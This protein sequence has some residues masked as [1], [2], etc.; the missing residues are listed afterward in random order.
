LKIGYFGSPSL[1]ARLLSE[2]LD[3][4]IQIEFVVTNEDK[5]RGRSKTP[6]PTEVA[7]LAQKKGIPLFRFP[8]L[9][10]EEV[11]RELKKYPCELYF[12]FAYGKLLPKNIFTIPP[13]GTVNLHASLLPKL[14]GASPFQSA[15]LGGFKT[16][17]WTLQLITEELDAGD[18]LHSKEIPIDPD[19]S[20]GEL[21][22]SMLPSAVEICR[23]VLND[24]NCYYQ[25]RK[26]Q[27]HEEA[28]Y[29]KKIKTEMTIINWNQPAVEIHNQ[30]RA[31]NPSPVARSIFRNKVILIYKSRPVIHDR[32]SAIEKQLI[33]APP[34]ST[35]VFSEGKQ[36]RL[37]VNTSK[38][39]LELLQLQPENK[40]IMDSLSFINGYRLEEGEY[41]G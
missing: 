10:P 31:F 38:G 11:E 27:N 9:K 36:R 26:K 6:F 13:F 12:I 14:R 32:E 25:K 7:E 8:S 30:I 39:I 3:S 29:C 21:A 15:I 4:A 16:T 28:T 17:G 24:F 20:S 37:F 41:F 22:L 5:P 18:V 2:L 40:K 33:N 23:E 19:E 1:S 34:G 35:L